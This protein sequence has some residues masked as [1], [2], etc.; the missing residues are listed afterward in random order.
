MIHDCATNYRTIIKQ[1]NLQSN[2][3]NYIVPDFHQFAICCIIITMIKLSFHK[4]S[5][6]KLVLSIKFTAQSQI[7]QVLSIKINISKS[8]LTLT[9]FFCSLTIILNDVIP[10]IILSHDAITRSTSSTS[11]PPT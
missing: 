7:S 4:C 5:C 10:Q 9:F 8:N 3:H 2:F 1:L 6:T 11:C